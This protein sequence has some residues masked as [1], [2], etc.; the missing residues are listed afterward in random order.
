MTLLQL[1]MLA[2]FKKDLIKA[3]EKLKEYKPERVKVV[4][5]DDAD[6]VTSASII[7]KVLRYL[8][9]KPET[10][11][12]EKAFPEVL[13]LIHVDRNGLIIYVDIGSAHVDYIAKLD[14]GRNLTLILDHHDTSPSPS[15]HV[16]NLNPELYGLS[17]ETFASGAAVC[18]AFS[19]VLGVTDPHLAALAI[20]GSTEIPGEP[21]GLN[22][23]ALQDAIDAKLA[24]VKIGERYKILVSLGAE[25]A[26][27]EKWSTQLTILSSVGYYSGGPRLALELCLEKPSSDVREVVVKL[28]EDRKNANQRLLS[29][30]RDEGLRKD[31]FIQ[32]FHADDI[33]K[34]MGTKVLG[35]FLSFLSYQRR[36]VERDKYLL[37]FMNMGPEIPNLGKLRSNYVK[38]SARAPDVLSSLITDGSRPPL[39]TLLPE[40][41]KATHGFGDGHTVAASGVIPRGREK[42][43]IENMLMLLK[44]KKLTRAS[45]LLEFTSK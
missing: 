44:G 33:F 9:L 36:V 14:R 25:K 2:S 21:I 32:W 8:D 35:T 15:E 7:Y 29:K 1:E 34:N 26:S 30:I 28:E 43:F 16:L 42:E 31:G 10:I 45:T 17:G 23:E 40:A 22:R 19:K 37:G 6:G 13:E 5:H 4:F 3:S 18:Y 27:R 12:I 11:C 39:S 24:E 41:A 20:I 38:V